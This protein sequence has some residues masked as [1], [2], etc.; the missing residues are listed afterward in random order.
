MVLW[1]RGGF[2]NVVDTWLILGSKSDIILTGSLTG[3]LRLF[4][5]SRTATSADA[6]DT[7]VDAKVYRQSDQKL[8][9]LI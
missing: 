7:E 4:L 5:P 1:T 8:F 6:H 3:A 9:S 2:A